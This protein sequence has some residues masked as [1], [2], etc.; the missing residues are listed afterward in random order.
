MPRRKTNGPPYQSLTLFLLK[1]GLREYENALEEPA[2]LTRYELKNSVPYEGAVFMAPQRK[3]PPGWLG[4]LQEGTEDKLANLFNASTSAVLFLRASKRVFAF[5]FGY[6]RSLLNPAR[7]ERSFGL[8]VVL[9]TVDEQCLNSV[10]S[11]TVQELT[12]QTRRQVSRASGLAAFAIDKEEDLLGFVRGTPRDP[13]FARTVAGADALL[14]SAS[15]KFGD[16]GRKCREILKAYR[17]N[18]YKKRGFEF[19]D[20]V[21]SVTDPDLI[22]SLDGDLVAAFLQRDLDKIYMAPPEIVDWKGTKGFSFAKAAEPEPDLSVASFFDQTRKPDEVDV[23]RLKRQRVYVHVANATEPT[24]GWPVYRTLVAELDRKG[25][26]YI[27]SGG[28]WFEIEKNFAER[29]AKRVGRIKFANL[30]LPAACPEEEERDYNIR[31]AQGSGRY[32][33]DRNCP[34][35]A[36]DEIELCDLYAS[37]NTF[38]HVKRWKASSTL[39][40]LFAQGRVSAEA[41]LSDAGFRDEARKLLKK[42]APSLGSQIPVGRPTPSK[43]TVVFAIIKGGKKGWKRSLPFFSQLR[44]VRSAES[45]RNL[46]FEVRLERIGVTN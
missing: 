4:F 14:F 6:G 2:S 25:E 17:S 33:V 34:R 27:L 1:T 39:S 9:N 41:F 22:A 38:V 23:N 19:V 31:A 40:H 29:I 45:L 26:R 44:L 20:H 3:A 36:G 11:K 30:G 16:L 24:R 35:V 5:T 8:R 37:K 7:I 43:Y 42:Q 21:R 12:V 18:E 13:Q 15:I 28:E 46:G 32:C 10:D